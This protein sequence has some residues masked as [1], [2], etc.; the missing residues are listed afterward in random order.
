MTIALFDSNDQLVGRKQGFDFSDATAVQGTSRYTVIVKSR[1][2]ALNI[3][4]YE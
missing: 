2:S 4:P 3:A 1:N